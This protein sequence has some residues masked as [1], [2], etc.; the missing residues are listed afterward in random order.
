MFWLFFC[1]FLA[2]PFASP[3]AAWYVSRQTPLVQRL[4]LTMLA[5]AVSMVAG[6]LAIGLSTASVA[7]NAVLWIV[8]WLSFAVLGMSA[9]RLRPKALGYLLGSLAALPGIAGL[10]F[11]TVGVMGLMGAVAEITGQHAAQLAPRLRCHVDLVEDQES[12][13]L[14][15]EVTL[16]RQSP[17]LPW[18]E[19][20]PRMVRL[21]DVDMQPDQACRRAFV[22]E[23]GA[24]PPST[25]QKPGKTP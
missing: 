22:H 23:A 13:Q 9:F 1:S 16:K 18:F 19:Y 10:L 15:Y 24:P 17:V 25:L 2:T 3:V 4:M 7:I 14:V 21:D 6:A 12:S 11:A 5:C 20:G 8:A